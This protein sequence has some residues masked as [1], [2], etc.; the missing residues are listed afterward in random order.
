METLHFLIS[1][2][3]ISHRDV[4]THRIK[5]EHVYLALLS[6][7][8][9]TSWN[10]VIFALGNLLIYLAIYICSRR[11]LGMGDLRLSPLMGIYLSMSHE[12]FS[13][14]LRMNLFTWMTAG[15]AILTLLLLKRI[16][17]KNRIAFAP[18]MFLGVALETYI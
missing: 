16:S 17:V 14:V 12:E 7:I 6:S 4:K 13:A 8:V 15:V 11:Q 10:A 9:F 5:K 3:V 2:L 18:F 1:S